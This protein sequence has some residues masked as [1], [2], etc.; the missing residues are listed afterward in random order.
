MNKLNYR[1]NNNKF[2]NMENNFSFMAFAKG[3]ESKEGVVIKHYVGM[4][5]V[6]IVAVNP[7]KEELSKIYGHEVTNERNY[8]TEVERNGKTLK[9]VMISFIA[10]P[11]KI[12]DK[13]EEVP[14][15]TVPIVFYIANDYIY[16][17][18]KSKVQIIDKY[19]R[20][21]WATVEEVKEHKIPVYK[22]GP[23]HIDTDYH[24]A[25]IG[26]PAVVEFLKKYLNLEEVEYF[27]REAGKYIQNANP[28]NC[29][30]SLSE[31]GEYFKGNFKELKNIIGYQ[32]D[33]KIR[34]A[35][36][37]RKAD[38]GRLFQVI[39]NKIVNKLRNTNY[40]AIDASI[41]QDKKNGG[42]RNTEY[43]VEP[44]HEY[45]VEATDF[46]KDPQVNENPFTAPL[47]NPF[48]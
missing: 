17:G 16:N 40:A 45:D 4:C 20:T 34:V 25:L 11:A 14:N 46:N 30:A 18:D 12:K 8:V 10:Q 26:E 35:F 2:K 3:N 37:V 5:P 15:I 44:L 41:Q 22:N 23:A 13:D 39:Y 19:G 27:N 29:E 48:A 24:P 42:L 31:I 43:S 28:D 33:N 7:T 38:D 9:Q 1:F 32:P 36:G 47:S 21:A 6:K